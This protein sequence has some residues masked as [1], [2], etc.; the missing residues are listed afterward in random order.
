MIMID[1]QRVLAAKN[2]RYS[3][4]RMNP[5]F[6]ALIDDGG[7]VDNCFESGPGWEVLSY[8]RKFFEIA[9]TPVE[10]EAAMDRYREYML[11]LHKKV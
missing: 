1:V 10:L 4:D 11:N 7:M 5:T 3:L 2:V 8:D 6:T 9:N